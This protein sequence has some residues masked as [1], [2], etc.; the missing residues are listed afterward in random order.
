MNEANVGSGALAPEQITGILSKIHA[1]AVTLF[2]RSVG[3]HRRCS[4]AAIVQVAAAP[5]ASPTPGAARRLGGACCRWRERAVDTATVARS[6]A[7]QRV[8][9]PN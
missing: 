4:V 7:G 8:V 1:A 5:A 9:A 2:T 6:D 3:R